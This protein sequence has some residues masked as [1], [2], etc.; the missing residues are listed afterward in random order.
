MIALFWSLCL[1][2]FVLEQKSNRLLAV[3]GTLNR[4]LMCEAKKYIG[5][6]TVLLRA[7]VHHGETLGTCKKLE[8]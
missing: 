4:V 8:G 6:R 3:E 5:D 7:I 2:F 1:C